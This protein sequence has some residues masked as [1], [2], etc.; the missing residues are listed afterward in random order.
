M[1]RPR[2]RITVGRLMILVALGG[3]VL[4][5]YEWLARPGRFNAR[6]QANLRAIGLALQA[7]HND[8]GSFPPAFVAD[9][10]GRPIHSW[11]ALLLPYLDEPDLAR[12]YRLDEPWDG[13]HNARLAGRV[14]TAYRCPAHD[15]DGCSGYAAI[16][17][18][19]T[20]WPGPVGVSQLQITDGTAILVVELAGGI[21]WLEPRDLSVGPFDPGGGW[22]AVRATAQRDLADLRR[23]G[24]AENSIHPY[25]PNR[26]M[27]PLSVAGRRVQIGNSEVFRA[28]L[29]IAGGEVWCIEEAY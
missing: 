3:L 15:E 14:P 8:H 23:Q 13:P 11:R 5:G 17:G 16:V 18:S 1:P 7:Y 24:L 22:E 28:E 21:P 2:I 29:S 25:G 6:C 12:A 20:A 10:R 9:D 27:A 4:G 26:L 19:G